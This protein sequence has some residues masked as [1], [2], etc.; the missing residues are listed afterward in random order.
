MNDVIKMKKYLTIDFFIN[1]KIKLLNK[2]NKKYN[3][4]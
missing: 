3:K 2:G 1:Y 4:V